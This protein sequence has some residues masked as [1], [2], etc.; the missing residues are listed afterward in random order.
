MTETKALKFLIKHQTK[1]G[2]FK[3][4]AVLKVLKSL[5]PSSTSCTS[6]GGTGEKHSKCAFGGTGDYYSCTTC[7]GSGKL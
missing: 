1:S 6:C 7:N 5:K 2:N 4:K 3:R